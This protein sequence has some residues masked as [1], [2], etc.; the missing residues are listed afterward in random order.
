M[1]QIP[2]F[3]YFAVDLRKIIEGSDPA[4][5][6]Q[7][8]DSSFWYLTD[9]TE[10]DPWYGLP[11]ATG[12][13]LYLNV[14]T[15]VGRKALSGETSSQSNF[16]RL[17]K[18]AFQSLAIFMPCFM[19]QQPSG[20][21]LYLATSMVFTLLQSKAMRN[22]AV[23]AAVGLPPADA[24]PP[25]QGELVKD[26]L[27]VMAARQAAKA[28]GGF[29]LG[30]GVHLTG[31][32][33][34]GFRTGSKRKSSIVVEKKDE[35]E[36]AVNG[37]QAIKVEFEVPDYTL[38]TFLVFPDLFKSSTPVP[39]LPRAREP[40]FHTSHDAARVATEGRLSAPASQLM[41]HISPSVMEAANRGERPAKMVPREALGMRERTKKQSGPITVDKLKSKR[42]KGKQGKK[43]R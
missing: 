11:I 38:R 13:L 35:E 37:A 31:A 2:F 22:D 41:P 9:L 33:V 42:K 26:F 32:N 6:Q 39:F 25:L 15:A 34:S 1:L 14:E 19:A 30:E 5:A 3:W 24:K 8:V 18:D 7:L 20:V 43:K 10:P 12:L 21:Q 27:E 40:V 4:L 17:L 29:V 36:E 28:R 23:R 16:A